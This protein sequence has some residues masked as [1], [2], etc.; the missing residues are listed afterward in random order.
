MDRLLARLERKLGRFAIGHLSYFIVGGMGLV[1]L[2][3]QTR[4]EIYDLLTLNF[5]MVREGQIWRLVTYL[6]LPTSDSLYWILFSL[7]WVWMVGHSLETEWG[8][9]KFNVFYVLGM[10]GT[11]AAAWISG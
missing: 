2:L 5:R 1:F 3:G 4:P 11:T 8:A 9:F 10:I 6:F 7:Y